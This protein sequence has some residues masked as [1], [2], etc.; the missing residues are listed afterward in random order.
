MV[1]AMS[2]SGAA[3]ALAACWAAMAARAGSATVSTTCTGERTGS[4]LA[5]CFDMFLTP[6]RKNCEAIRV[7]RG[8]PMHDTPN[9]RDLYRA[10]PDHR[11]LPGGPSAAEGC[12]GFRAL[13]PR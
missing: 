12:A 8:R 6:R 7:R 9:G 13:L 5:R 2:S 3:A 1:T 4:D 11:A 10:E